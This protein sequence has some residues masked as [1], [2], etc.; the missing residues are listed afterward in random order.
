[1]AELTVLKQANQEK[2]RIIK[3]LA[4]YW[5]DLGF[6][7]NFDKNG[8][9]LASI[10]QNCHGNP[11]N[12]CREMFQYWLN[13]NGVQPCSWRKLIELLED[14]DQQTLSEEIQKAIMSTIL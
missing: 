13:G 12:C 11:H 7:L 9:C 2:I 1:M 8:S 4:P 6:I 10:E 14:C 5:K 3:G